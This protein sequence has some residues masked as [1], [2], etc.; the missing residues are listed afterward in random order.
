M[1]YNLDTSKFIFG[2]GLALFPLFLL[3]GP[4]IS[5]V[6]LISIIF[7]SLFLIIK[8]KKYDFYLNKFAIFFLLFYLSTLYSTISNFYNFD[9]SKG[10]L[11]FLRIPLFALSIWFVLDRYNIFN[12]KIILF[13]VILFLAI[14]FDS[15]VQYYFDKNL[16]GYE[17]LNKSRISSF[18]RDEFILGSFLTRLI[19]IFLIYLIMEGLINDKKIQ[20]SY[21][22]L[23]SFACLI[24]YLS[25]ERTA[26]GLLILFFF[27]LFFMVKLLRK[28]IL[29][30]IIIFTVLAI[31]LPSLKP[32]YRTDPVERIFQKSFNQIIGKE[33]K[34]QEHK[35]KI[36]NKFYIFSHDHHG[37]YLLS[38]KI[39]K[40]HMII[41]TGIKGFRYLCRNKIYILENN[42]GCSTH[43]HN[44]YVQILVSNGL[45]GFSLLIFSFFYFVREIFLY[46]N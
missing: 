17:V 7:F 42:D 14:I 10:G 36:F 35:K 39:F 20:K 34:E 45:I 6:F 5:E 9:Y 15:L 25:G 8:E 32:S 13:F 44:T 30:L 40:D 27:T 11:F 4:L 37:H 23:I 43:P 41:G 46:K 28:F 38:Y 18:F 26:F 21:L 1:I 2:Y 33:K 29:Y 19:P 16:L 12:K 22:L 24:I 3:L 31:I